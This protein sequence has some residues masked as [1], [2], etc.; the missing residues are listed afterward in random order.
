VK[1]E[2]N[3]FLKVAESNLKKIE[4]DYEAGDRKQACESLSVLIDTLI[5]TENS[6]DYC[7]KLHDLKKEAF[8]L[9]GKMSSKRKQSVK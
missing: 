8:Q 5:K 6:L 7:P 3:T 9:M 4:K 1:P 2:L